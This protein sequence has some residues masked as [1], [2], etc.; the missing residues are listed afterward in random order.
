MGIKLRPINDNILVK[1]AQVKDKTAGGIIIPETAKDKPTRGV[2]ISVGNSKLSDE[3]KEGDVVLFSKWAG[4]TF[5]EDEDYIL[6]KSEEI[7]G[8]IN[9]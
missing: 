5:C 4:N 1:R 8:V 3:L 6:L 7:L 2:V 9:D